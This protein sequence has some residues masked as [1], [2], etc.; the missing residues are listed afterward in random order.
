[1]IVSLE[2]FCNFSR[3]GLGVAYAPSGCGVPGYRWRNAAAPPEAR[4]FCCEAR[5]W[6]V[7]FTDVDLTVRVAVA[8]GEAYPNDAQLLDALRAELARA[9]GRYR[10]G[11]AAQLAPSV[12]A[13]IEEHLVEI[14]TGEPVRMPA[15]AR[16]TAP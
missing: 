15:A 1:M 8:E 7:Y 4:T 16:G 13:L 9:V 3:A 5:A 10:D 2:T 11:R 6:L 12:R 14:E